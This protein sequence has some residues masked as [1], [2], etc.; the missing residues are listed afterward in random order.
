MHPSAINA[1]TED[2]TG[3][4]LLPNGLLIM[5]PPIAS[6][7]NMTKSIRKNRI[8]MIFML[9]LLKSDKYPLVVNGGDFNEATGAMSPY[10]GAGTSHNH[11]PL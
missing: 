6:I 2:K 10:E 9:F 3:S 11:N 7:K 4:L 8:A 1:M 5:S